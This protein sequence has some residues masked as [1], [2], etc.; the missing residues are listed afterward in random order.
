VC[1]PPQPP[2]QERDARKIGLATSR[3]PAS[4]AAPTTLW[5]VGAQVAT[6]PRNQ[7]EQRRVA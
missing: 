6:P 3:L 7:G 1:A 5:R 4:S 2:V